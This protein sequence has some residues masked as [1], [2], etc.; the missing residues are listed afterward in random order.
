M[1]T[2]CGCGGGSYCFGSFV[3]VC[4]RDYGTY[5]IIINNWQ[6]QRI[7]AAAEAT[8]HGMVLHIQHTL[9]RHLILLLKRVHV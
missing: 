9:T 3:G 7:K 1:E 6:P 4:T 2:Y 8:A 5:T